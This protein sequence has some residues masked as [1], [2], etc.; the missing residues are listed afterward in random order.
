MYDVLKDFASPVIT[1][2]TALVAGFITFTFNRNQA[3]LA[4]SQRDIALDKLKF[5]LFERRFSVYEAAR[6]F[7]VSI[8]TTGKVE[9]DALLKF[10][11]GMVEARW[12]LD[13]SVARYLKEDLYAKALDLETLSAELEGLPVGEE[14]NA[15][16][17]ERGEI[18]RWLN[19]Q[20]PVLDE[21]FSPFLKLEH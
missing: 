21:K 17:H 13:E 5:D 15:R 19:D 20:F 18:K 4:R 10:V 14:R 16:V 6:N 12:L 11:S 7:L 9:G 1:L 2:I 3:Q 8:L